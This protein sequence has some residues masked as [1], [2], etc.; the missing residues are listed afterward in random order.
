M[1]ALVAAKLSSGGAAFKRRFLDGVVGDGCA[2]PCEKRGCFVDGGI[3]FMV[4]LLMMVLLD[5]RREW[6][7]CLS[8]DDLSIVSL[9]MV[10][11]LAST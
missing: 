8:R 7:Y 11:L 9:V 4:L 10:V 1:L 5:A 6:C 2:F 3:P